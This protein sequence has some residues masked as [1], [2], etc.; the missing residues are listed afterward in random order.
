MRDV[1]IRSRVAE[2]LRMLDDRKSSIDFSFRRRGNVA[3]LSPVEDLLSRLIGPILVLM[4][5]YS[6]VEDPAR[7]VAVGLV[8]I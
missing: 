6:G 3:N 1:D 8:A 5:R 2:L 7:D 4:M